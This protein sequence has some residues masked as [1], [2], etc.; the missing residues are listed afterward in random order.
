MAE[1][2]DLDIKDTSILNPI[3]CQNAILGKVAVSAQQTA[4]PIP[5]VPLFFSSAACNAGLNGVLFPDP[6]KSVACPS[7]PSLVVGPEDNCLR[8]LSGPESKTKIL[9]K[10]DV[11]VLSGPESNVFSDPDDRLFSFYV[12]PDYEVYFFK[13]DPRGHSVESLQ[14][15][16]TLKVSGDTVQVNACRSELC[17]PNGETFFAANEAVKLAAIANSATSIITGTTR[18]RFTTSLFFRSEPYDEQACSDASRFYVHRT[19]FFVV[20]RL[21]EFKR[22]I[23]DMCLRNRVVHIGT[24]RL[25]DVWQ[26]QSPGCD[27]FVTA[28]CSGSPQDEVCAC[29]TQQKALDATFGDS[30]KVPVCCFG[31]DPDGVQGRSCAFNDQAYKTKDM[32]DNCCTVAQCSQKSQ[33]LQASNP[34]ANVNC[35]GGDRV[36]L[37]EKQTETTLFIE[38]VVHE[39]QSVP[40]WVVIVCIITFVS[41]IAYAI[42]L[43]F[44]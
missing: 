44:T 12:P 26:P 5:P 6:E 37:P 10:Q 27:A 15:S 1:I 22:T 23:L 41:M 30:A 21:Q 33:V 11:N 14:S 16:T 13:E 29:F 25:N 9:T 31:T 34:D 40:G 4:N 19:P 20:I 39:T 36:V 2:E 17:L 38:P 18:S 24:A 7:D 35:I 43:V 28:F 8:V 42:L 3:L 32:I